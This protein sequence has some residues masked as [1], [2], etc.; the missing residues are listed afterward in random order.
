MAAPEEPNLHELG[1]TGALG[2]CSTWVTAHG[3]LSG[4]TGFEVT[5]HG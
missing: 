5:P 4:S 3:S 2:Q 1:G